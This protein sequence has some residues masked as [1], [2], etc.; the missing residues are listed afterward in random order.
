MRR[1]RQLAAAG[2]A[3]CGVA[4]LFA[5]SALYVPGIAFVL[6]A[7]LA[8]AWVWLAA[9]R[10]RVELEPS[11]TCAYEGEPIAVA[12]CVRRGLLRGGGAELRV[13]ELHVP[14][15]ARRASAPVSVSAVAERRGPQAVGPARLCVSDPLGIC[16]GELRSEAHEVLV[17]PRVYPVSA[18]IVGRV[19][20][21]SARARRTDAELHLDSLRA[22]DASGPASR[23]HWP[24]VAR[25][26]ELMAREF[27]A[28][29]EPRILVVVD[30]RVP[31]SEE[32]LDR[33]LRAAASLCVHLARSGGCEVLLPG[34][35]R[36]RA[37]GPALEGWPALHVRL[38]LVRAGTQTV[39]GASR[40]L[41]RTIVSVTAARERD[42]AGAGMGAYWRVGPHPLAG[43]EVAFDV[44]GCGGQ[45]IEEGA[46]RIAA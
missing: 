10:A 22:Y 8:P 38:A 19:R 30:A 3:L 4:A 1:A 18:G 14:L 11:V 43:L 34:D 29:A 41:A 26:G 28:E 17:L 27:V 25:T 32:A 36:P 35:A 12:V 24:T 13:G 20:C 33:A 9:A 31:A 37:I 6:L 21:G 45:L 23:I 39:S 15:P 42:R 40:H 5:A 2:V 44:A 7:V 46:L 16:V